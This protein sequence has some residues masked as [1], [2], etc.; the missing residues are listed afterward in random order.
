M[1]NFYSFY[2][3]EQNIATLSQELSWSH[4][5]E[6]ITIENNLKKNFHF[7]LSKKEHWSVRILLDR[8][9]SMLFER[10][11]ISKKPENLIAK[12]MELLKAEG[13]VTPDLVFKDP[14]VLDFLGLED[15][16]ESD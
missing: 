8:I 9:N 11:A 7:Q 3:E 4:F 5:V 6:L 14:Y 2:Q 10:T 16:S 13:Q 1:I 12:E 15:S